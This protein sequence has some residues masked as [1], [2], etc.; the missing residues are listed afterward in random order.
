MP[1]ITLNLW[2]CEGA[3]K[4]NLDTP[5]PITAKQSNYSR[6]LP[7]QKPAGSLPCS[8]K[9]FVIITA[10][11]PGSSAL[12]PFLQTYR[13]KF[14]I[15]LS[16]HTCFISHPPRVHSFWKNP[17]QFLFFLKWQTRFYVHT[18]LKFCTLRQNYNYFSHIY[19]HFISQCTVTPCAAQAVCCNIQRLHFAHRACLRVWYD[20]HN[21]QLLFPRT[22]FT[23]SFCNG[24]TT[25]LIIFKKTSCSEGLNAPTDVT[26]IWAPGI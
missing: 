13:L 25:A 16:L 20:S 4:N 19:V 24:G 18:K 8:L 6:N 12:Y 2:K 17:S 7:F 5:G 14:C 11:R 23:V 3:L 22:P 10:P 26:C 15:H 21:K 9:P 1:K